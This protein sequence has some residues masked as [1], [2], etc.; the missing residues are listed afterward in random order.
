MLLVLIAIY[1][2]LLLNFR[3]VT[4]TGENP[5][6]VFILADDMGVGD[7][8]YNGGKARTPGIDRLAE[9]GMTFTDVHT[10][11]SLCTPSRYG[12]LTGRYS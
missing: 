2:L 1:I 12:L 6:I 9:E 7:V 4:C 8:S 5:N 3:E 10:T 11:S